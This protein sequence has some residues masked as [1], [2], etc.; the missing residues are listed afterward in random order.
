MF[1]Q[2][3]L[4]AALS[5]SFLLLFS[6]LLLHPLKSS[7]YFPTRNQETIW[8]RSQAPEPTWFKPWLRSLQALYVG[9]SSLVSLILSFQFCKTR[10]SNAVAVN[11]NG[12]RCGKVLTAA[13]GLR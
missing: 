11:V 3:A 7:L 2:K 8:L 6:Q 10:T 1:Q 9:A 12:G 13:C 4:L 5:L